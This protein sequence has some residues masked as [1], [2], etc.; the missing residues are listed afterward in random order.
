MGTLW[1]V[2]GHTAFAA[3]A[4]EGRRSRESL[5]TVVFRPGEPP[6]RVAFAVSR[7]VGPAV[8]RNRVRRRLRAVLADEALAGGDYLVIADP[9]AGALDHA[10]LRRQVR[11]ALERL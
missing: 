10:E 7:K 9:G 8:V 2:R 11:G 6:P 5:V 4:R 3:L 1:R